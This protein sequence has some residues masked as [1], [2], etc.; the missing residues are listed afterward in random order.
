MKP[1]SLRLHFSRQPRL[2]WATCIFVC[3]AHI[4]GCY[5]AATCRGYPAPPWWTIPAMYVAP[6]LCGLPALFDNDRSLRHRGVI[7][8][9]IAMGITHA[10]A[11]CNLASA[12][13]HPG[14]HIG[15]FGLLVSIL[16]WLPF[17]FVTIPT[18]AFCLLFIE[19]VL[20]DCWGLLRR[21]PDESLVSTTK[22]AGNHAVHRSGDSAFPDG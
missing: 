10:V 14:F 6:F 22:I 15:F 21:F 4:V 7:L 12:R 17:A 11:W 1:S 3:V 19:R 16:P 9:A 8:T 13:P 2:H 18:M 5:T 20:G